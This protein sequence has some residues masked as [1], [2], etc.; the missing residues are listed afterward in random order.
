LT[1][2]YSPEQ[3]TFCYANPYVTPSYLPPPIAQNF[4]DES[5]QY[6]SSNSNNPSMMPGNSSTDGIE[7]DVTNESPADENNESENKSQ[8]SSSSLSNDG[9]N[10][11]QQ[12]STE[13]SDDKRRDTNSV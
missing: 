11:S 10:N 3:L 13:Q 2:S 7:G 8:R 4:I 6:N 1:A 9:T 5:K 12:M